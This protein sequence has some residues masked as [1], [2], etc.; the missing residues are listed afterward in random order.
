MTDTKSVFHSFNTAHT[1]QELAGK[2]D[3]KRYGNELSQGMRPKVGEIPSAG[4]QFPSPNPHQQ[5]RD[6]GG[7]G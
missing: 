3:G 7:G 6:W 2:G 4:P 1:L 5:A